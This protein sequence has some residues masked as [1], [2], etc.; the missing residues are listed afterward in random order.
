MNSAIFRTIATIIFGALLGLGLYHFALMEEP[1]SADEQNSANKQQRLP[2]YWVAPM[3]DNYRRDKPGK[4]PM[5]MDLVPVY[6]DSPGS[7]GSNPGAVSIDPHI[8]T[9]L[10]VRTSTVLRK[11]LSTEISTVGYVQYDEDQLVHIHPRIDGWVEKLYIKAAGNPVKKGEALYTLYSPKLVNAQEELLIAI[12]RKTPSLIHAARKRMEAL[13]L[14]A[15]FINKLEE[16]LQVQQTITFYAPQAGVVADLKIR[17]GFYVQPGNTL[18]SIARL[19]QIWVEAEIFERDSALVKKGQPVKMTLDYLPGES[20]Q[21]KVDYVYPSLHRDTRTARARLKFDNSDLKLKPNM[22]AKIVIS[23]SDN[24][25]VIVAPREAIIRTADQNRVVL[26]LGDGLFK[27]IEVTP[28]RISNQEVEILSGL[29]EGDIIVDSAQFLIDSESSKN[30]DFKRFNSEP[31]QRYEQA[32]VIGQIQSISLNTREVNIDRLG[33][34][35]W[36]RPAANVDFVFDDTVNSTNYREGDWVEF[37]FEVREQLTIIDMQ[38]HPE[39][40]RHD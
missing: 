15:S 33:I 28:G 9:T 38:A 11:P 12:K 13:H 14:T 27:S 5:G 34:P 30:S 37:R 4:S 21:G 29:E 18:L 25:E 36:D 17:E 10:G 31:P 23:I 3:D 16:D 32:T 24:K 35:K 39:G 8:M 20:W 22:F 40:A 7:A 2:L 6:N 19:D 1:S 26:A